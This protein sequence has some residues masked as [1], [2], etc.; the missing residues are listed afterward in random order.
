V[1]KS[2]TSPDPGLIAFSITS[3]DRR[4]C[5]IVRTEAGFVGTG[6]ESGEGAKPPQ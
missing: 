4:K 1:A 5:V 2:I 6:E 3:P